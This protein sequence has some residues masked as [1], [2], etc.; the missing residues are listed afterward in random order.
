MWRLHCQTMVESPQPQRTFDRARRRL[1]PAMAP[2]P[3]RVLETPQPHTTVT[4]MADGA[5]RRSPA[6]TARLPRSTATPRTVNVHALGSSLTGLCNFSWQDCH[7][8]LLLPMPPKLSAAPCFSTA[9]SWRVQFAI[10][11]PI[12]VKE[13]NLLLLL[14]KYSCEAHSTAEIF[15]NCRIENCFM[16]ICSMQRIGR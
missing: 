16:N 12:E 8:K 4:A 1:P 15:S 10:R 9:Q 11:S 14:G 13:E 6:P 7:C 2:P 5:R 3:H